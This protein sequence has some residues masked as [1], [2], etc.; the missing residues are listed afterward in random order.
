MLRGFCY[1]DVGDVGLYAAEHNTVVVLPYAAG[2]ILGTDCHVWHHEHHDP[3][4]TCD[5][6]R[7]CKL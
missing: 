7:G 4:Y 2:V 1:V 3:P 5:L 6:K